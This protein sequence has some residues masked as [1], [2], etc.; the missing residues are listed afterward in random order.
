MNNT[1]DSKGRF[2]KGH[3]VPNANKFSNGN[4]AGVKHGF[5]IGGKP[6]PLWVVWNTMRGRCSANNKDKWRNYGARGIRVC[7]EWSEFI[8]FYNWAC[9][10]WIPGLQLDRINN[11][12]N[13][14]PGNCRF[15]TLRENINNQRRTIYV[16]IHGE[17]MSTYQ[18][19]S[20]YKVVS[21]LVVRR[22]LKRGWSDEDAVLTP[23]KAIWRYGRES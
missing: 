21:L 3:I 10:K 11:D 2:L 8:N 5:T 13:Y 1:R 9:D 19:C 18:A 23:L 17:R 12:G 20:Q 4:T 6:H 15:V 16:T 22:R 7:D 14:E